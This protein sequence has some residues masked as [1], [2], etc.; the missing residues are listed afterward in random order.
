MQ[1]RPMRTELARVQIEAQKQSFERNGFEQY[2]FIALGSACEICK[3]LDGKHFGVE[4]MMPGENAPP[5]HPNCRCSVAAWVDDEEYEEW[6]DYLDK[7][8]TTEDWN[9]MKKQNSNMSAI[10]DSVKWPER[11]KSISTEKYRELSAYARNCGIALE[12]FKRFDG[13]IDVI[14]QIIDDADEIAE[15]FPD[16]KKGKNKLTISLDEHMKADDFAITRGHIIYINADAFRDI[17]ILRKEYDKLAREG[18][19][20]KGTDYRSIIRHETGHVV[21]N[22]Y[23]IDGLEISKKITGFSSTS[24][25]ME[26]LKD[27]LS[28]YAS[29][30][31]DGLEIVSECF[32]GVFSGLNNEFALKVVDECDRIKSKKKVIL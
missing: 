19:F 14:K 11:R 4:K 9:L 21:A 13:D 18:W 25:L 22:T 12:G 27:N 20:V 10:N 1:S 29:E 17:N 8:G 31:E 24:E 15:L 30:Y 32:S 16:I 6:L 7:G 28:T 23:S 5:M 2:E 3:E 26:Y